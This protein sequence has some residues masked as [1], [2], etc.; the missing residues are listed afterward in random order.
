[1]EIVLRLLVKGA[2]NSCLLRLSSTSSHIACFDT[3][4]NSRA[5]LFASC[6]VLFVDKGVWF[7]VRFVLVGVRFDTRLG[8]I[9]VAGSSSELYT[10]SESWSIKFGD[11]LPEHR[12]SISVEKIFE[13][14][15]VKSLSSCTFEVTRV[16]ESLE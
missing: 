12:V 14:V 5:E 4:L 6:F 3:L 15:L 7:F 1:L 10:K 9:G 16:C 13:G 2:V 11:S 8:L